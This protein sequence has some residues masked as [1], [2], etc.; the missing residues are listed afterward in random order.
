MQE[1]DFDGFRFDGITS[2]LY[3]HHGLGVGFSGKFITF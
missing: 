3:L 2:M 1:F